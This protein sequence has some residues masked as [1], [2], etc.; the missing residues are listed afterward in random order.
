MQDE[1]IAVGRLAAE[2]FEDHHFERP[3]KQI[4][5]RRFWHRLVRLRPR[6]NRY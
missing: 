5:N 1:S 3:G 6:V 2:G 4:A